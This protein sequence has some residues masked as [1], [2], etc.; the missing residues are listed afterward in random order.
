MTNDYNFDILNRLSRETAKHNKNQKRIN[1]Q[2]PKIPN[3][4]EIFGSTV[5]NEIAEQKLL[6]SKKAKQFKRE[7]L[8]ERTKS[9]CEFLRCNSLR[10]K[11]LREFDP[12]SG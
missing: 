7:L 5:K 10:K 2:T 4:K 11:L 8:K 6:S 3:K 1:A 12:G 9:R